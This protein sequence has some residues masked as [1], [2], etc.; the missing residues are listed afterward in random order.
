[1]A[2]PIGFDPSVVNTQTTG[3]FTLGELREWNG[4][5]YRFVQVV[6]A[7]CADGTV[8]CVYDATTPASG[9]VIGAN[10]TTALAGTPIASIV[11]GIGI[12]AITINYFGFIQVSGVH[13]N[14][15]SGTS[16][17]GYWQC[18]VATNDTCGDATAS[19]ARTESIFG[20]C[21]KATATGRAHVLLKGL[22]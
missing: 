20:Q 1:M 22:A 19:I 21:V 17:L 10:R 6:T 13:T 2:T 18:A 16:T 12:G 3:S 5:M 9:K 8:M 14:V 15:L 7:A 4:K 11:V